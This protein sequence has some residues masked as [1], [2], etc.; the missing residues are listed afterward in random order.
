MS[1]SLMLRKYKSKSQWVITSVLRCLD[2]YLLIVADDLG[3]WQ[4][5]CDN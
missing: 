5:K 2:W 1:I 3:G 4:N